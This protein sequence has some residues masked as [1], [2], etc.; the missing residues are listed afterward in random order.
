MSSA[1]RLFNKT[2]QANVKT[3]LLFYPGALYH[4]GG[5][6]SFVPLDT[7]VLVRRAYSY[8][9][10]SSPKQQRG[11][12]MRRQTEFEQRIVK[13]M[14]LVLD[15]TLDLSDTGV[16]AFHGKN[17][18]FG[19]LAEFMKLVDAGRIPGGSVLIVENIDRL[20]RENV[21]DAFN[22]FSRII[23]A[24][25]TLVTAEPYDV[26]TKEEV[27]GNV[28][29]LMVPL[30]YMMRAHDESRMKSHRIHQ[31]WGQRRKRA[32]ES[33]L[34]LTAHCPR[35]LRVV[36]KGKDKYEL[37][38]ERA[39][40]VRDI[41]LWVRE[42]LGV[43]RIVQKLKADGVPCF[44][45]KEVWHTTYVRKLLIWPAVYGEM[46]PYVQVD[47]VR[48]T[49]GEPIPNYFPAVVSR[50]EFDLV[51]VTMKDRRG[52]DGRPAKGDGN[53][54][55]GIV[56][57]AVDRCRMAMRT[58]NQ[59]GKRYS[60]LTSNSVE[61][62]AKA[63]EGRRFPYQRFEEAVL[64][65][66]EELRPEDVS[67]RFREEKSH[68]LGE[69]ERLSTEL[70]TVDQGLKEFEAQLF[71]PSNKID[72]AV[73][74]RLMNVMSGQKE[75]LRARLAPLEA[76]AAS[77]KTEQSSE[78]RTVMGLMSSLPP[79]QE[80]DRFR[81][82]VRTRLRWLLDSIWVHIEKVNQMRQFAHVQV[83]LR[84]G[85]RKDLVVP[86]FSPVA[87]RPDVS[88]ARRY[89]DVDFRTYTPTVTRGRGRLRERGRDDS[90]PPPLTDSPPVV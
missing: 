54:F 41:F 10:F 6:S 64:G 30:V 88:P 77:T 26:Y 90:P 87:G 68:L 5:L 35:W 86:S 51:R 33:G 49:Y 31:A 66:L 19:A 84:T 67:D 14:D 11:D 60:Y 37:V 4:S 56:W 73:I 52:K 83:F 20:S 48:K 79:G 24:D 8:K 38:E 61:K 7:E 75:D 22:L 21:L 44:G 78:G 25:I 55:T 15:D 47:G 50:E 62:G 42:G 32:V 72:R 12:S 63:G 81:R 36:G 39:Q 76:E 17:N 9:R 23:S 74:R 80:R 85:E 2:V 89:D 13:E 57:H 65:E 27:Q 69:I 70:M 40:V 16:S 1:I 46:Q 28:I 43:N 82:K 18:K 53:L 71:D 59:R 45:K 29:K 3:L 34:A 58:N